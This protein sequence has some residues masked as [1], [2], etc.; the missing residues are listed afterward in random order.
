MRTTLS[1]HPRLR[2]CSKASSRG[3]TLMETMIVVVIISILMLLAL[4]GV[5][6][7]IAKAHDARR[8][9]DLDRISKAFEEYYNDHDCY[10]DVGILEDCGGTGLAPY[11]ERIPCDPATKKPYV[12][13]PMEGNACGGY[14]SCARLHNL[15]DPDIIERGCNPVTG[16]GWEDAYNYCL[17]SGVSMIRPGF[18]PLADA[19]PTN[20]PSGSPTPAP[21]CYACMGVQLDPEISTCNNR[22]NPGPPPIT[23]ARELGCTYSFASSN[24]DNLC[25]DPTYNC[26]GD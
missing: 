20:M 10:P 23:D 26:L 15:A 5:R 3:L 22:C 2:S 9:G 13:V 21:G 7:Q 25:G 4:F 24:C 11:L 6:G 12:Y 1:G 18:D 19:T 16:C 17:V 8:K 14:A